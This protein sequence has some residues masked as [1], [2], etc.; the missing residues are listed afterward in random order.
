MKIS[1]LKEFFVLSEFLNF[2]K[3]AEHLFMTQPAL[4]RHISILEENLNILLV[5]RTTKYVELT[6]A[7]KLLK[8][9]LPSILGEYEL[10]VSKLNAMSAKSL[11]CLRVGIP[12]VSVNDYLGKVPEVFKQK[13]PNI[14]LT[15]YPNGPE[16]NISAL[17][18]SELDIIMVSNIPF[19]NASLLTFHDY[20]VEPM[21]VVCREDSPLAKKKSVTLYDLKDYNFL[22]NKSSY[23]GA[24]W[25]YLALQCKW[26]GFTP[27]GPIYS[28]NMDST[29]VSVRQ[30]QGIAIVS[31]HHKS[32]A[33]QGLVYVTLEETSCIQK[34]SLA[35]RSADNNPAIPKFIEVFSQYGYYLSK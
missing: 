29:L 31:M 11:Y 18:H 12:S 8:E 35:Y 21:I 7:G 25:E 17:F 6:E 14:G 27:K 28:N 2:T 5:E 20:A 32:L 19:P 13:Y 22:C 9:A 30:G 34:M 4:S 10:V 15:F 24:I 26:S 16:E 1:Y 23:Y 33:L 3:A